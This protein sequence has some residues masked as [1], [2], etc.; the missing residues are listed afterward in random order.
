MA[1]GNQNLSSLKLPEWC[2]LRGFHV[3]VTLGALGS[4]LGQTA[5]VAVP[6]Y[7]CVSRGALKGAAGKGDTMVTGGW[8]NLE[9][10]QHPG[11]SCASALSGRTAYNT[12]TCFYLIFGMFLQIGLFISL[13][14]C[15]LPASGWEI[16]NVCFQCIQEEAELDS[17]TSCVPVGGSPVQSH[18]HKH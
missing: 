14:E 6:G 11:R 8:K 13:F 9:Q 3:K 18:T 16:G 17:G 10:S 7:Q 5:I 4:E 1:E 12:E 2:R 15:D